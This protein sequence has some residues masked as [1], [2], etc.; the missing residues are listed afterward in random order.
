MSEYDLENRAKKH[1]FSDS[2][3]LDKLASARRKKALNIIDIL[4]PFILGKTINSALSVGSSYCLIEEEI[5]M[6]LFPHAEFICT[7]L[8]RK[9]LDHFHQPQLT[10]I[11]KSATDLDF[12]D[13][14]FDFIMAHQVLEHINSYPVILESFRRICKPGGIIYINVPNPFSPMI[15]KLPNGEWP[16][17]LFK[18]FL[19]H[20]AKKI[21]RD[22]MENTEKYHT[23]FSERYLRKVMRDFSVYDLRKPR[24][25]QELKHRLFH[26]AT[27]MLPNSLLFIPVQTNLWCLIKKYRLSDK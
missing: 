11:V 19:K 27:D 14:S 23:G 17:P 22:F 25:K 18:Y 3:E 16:K 13:E 20:N 26:M 4:E 5:R 1:F 24:L 10:K 15:G 6:A 12:P 2:N 9:A 21:N 8:D 7:D